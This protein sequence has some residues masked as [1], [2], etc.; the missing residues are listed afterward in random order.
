ML[1][2]VVGPQSPNVDPHL[3]RALVEEAALEK[4]LN[5]LVPFRAASDSIPF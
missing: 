4:P 2:G 1:T 5:A 3:T